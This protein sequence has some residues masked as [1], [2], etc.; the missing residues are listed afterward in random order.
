M[1]KDQQQI[2]KL[3]TRLKHEKQQ[4]P[5]KFLKLGQIIEAYDSQYEQY[6]KNKIEE[7]QRMIG[8]SIFKTLH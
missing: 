2:N 5:H 4:N 7:M 3:Q 8:E 1:K 6:V